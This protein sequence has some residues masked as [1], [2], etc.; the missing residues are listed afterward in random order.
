MI[1]LHQAILNCHEPH[2]SKL[3]RLE[4]EMVKRHAQGSQE[5]PEQKKFE[6]PSE[7]EHLFQVTDI[8]TDQDEMGQKLKLDS[9]TV[10]AKCEVVGG[11]EEGRTL[12]QRMTLDDK[13]KG[14]WATRIFLK[15]T[16][17]DYKGDITIDT[18]MWCGLQ[19]YAT[20]VHNGDYANIKEYNFDKKIEQ[21]KSF[22]EMP[23]TNPGGITDPKDI[24]WEA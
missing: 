23:S 6:K 16:G 7:R 12:L 5:E 15:A 21:R 11:D 22:K 10:S 3:L 19:F 24:A 14:F 4:K 20:V 9:D 2:R 17:Q 8:F 18:D 13:N 1:T